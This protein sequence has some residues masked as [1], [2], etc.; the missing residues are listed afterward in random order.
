MEDRLVI[1]LA[2]QKV[3][4]E[5]LHEG[6]HGMSKTS[7]LLNTS[8]FWVGKNRHREDS[9]VSCRQCRGTLAMWGNTSMRQRQPIV[10]S[11]QPRCP[12]Q[13]VSS[14]LFHHNGKNYLVIL[15]HYSKWY[16]VKQLR[17]LTSRKVISNC[18]EPFSSFGVL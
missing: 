2:Q 13:I 17:S 11:E 12:F 9:L 8:V 18:D 16:Q 1:L 7:H 15:D 10:S 14:D 6:H 3:I 5:K 4:L